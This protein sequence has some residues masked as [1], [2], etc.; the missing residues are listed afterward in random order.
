MLMLFV[1]SMIGVA[2]NA[3]I[4]FET[5]GQGASWT[6]T[7]F[8]NN[9]NPPLDIVANPNVAGANTSATVAKFTALQAGNPWAGCES[10][11]GTTNLGPFVLDATN[12]IIKIKVWKTVISDVGIKL[13]AASGWALPEIKVANTLTNQWEEL[14]FDFSN[15][16]NPPTAEG[17]YD[18]IAIFPDFNL[19]GRTQDNII[20]FDEITFGAGTPPPAPMTPAPTPTRNSADV[21]SIYSNAYT[22]LSGVDLNP[23]W[24]QSTVVADVLIQG[25][26]TL[27][28]TNLNYQGIDLGGSLDV[29]NR[30]FL[31]L[32]IWSATSTALNVFLISTGPIET[33][34]ALTVPTAGWSSVDIPLAAFSPVAL[35]DV[36]QFKFDGNGEFYMDNLYFYSATIP[37]PTAAAPTPTHAASNVISIYS[38]AYTALAGSNLNPG[39]GQSTVVTEVQLQGNNTMKYSN[40]NYQ[41]IEL[42]GNT[43][44]T[45]MEFLHIDVW[46]A[47]STAL[48]VYLISPGPVEKAYAI[49]VPTTGWSSIDIPLSTFS[50]VALNSVIQFKFDG[51]GEFYMD[52]L[53]FYRNPVSVNEVEANQ[54]ELSVFPNPAQ[55]GTLVKLNKT[56]K[57][58]EVVDL[59]GKT[60]WVGQQNNIETA[61]LSKGIYLVKSLS[62]DNKMEVTK[63][64]IQ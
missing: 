46:S 56:V 40:L 34:F 48:N 5:G 45:S 43:D 60:I 62:V 20:Y 42:A 29:T 31:H 6:W 50:P 55:Q 44:V 13:I 10:A 59:Q 23:N 11:H 16:T 22:N 9:T 63:L 49:T 64:V 18:Q 58:I 61:Q 36:I 28:Y 35:N 1:A 2:Q 53:L 7:V 26:N 4:N 57:Q 33:A 32:D 19:A 52:N 15:Y 3:P 14:T 21:T 41:G 39:W 24:G 12:S 38:D 25:N 30:Q 47:L 27:K 54:K 51:N 17:Q 8:E 37:T